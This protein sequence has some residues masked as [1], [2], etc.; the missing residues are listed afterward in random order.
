MLD[1]EPDTCASYH[2]DKHCV[3]CIL[4]YCQ[5]LYTAH[6]L[7]NVD[8]WCQ[9]LRDMGVVPM[10]PTHINH[11]SAIWVR[12][13]EANYTWV[14]SLLVSLC[15]SYTKRYG[16]V[17]AKQYDAEWLLDHCPPCYHR[18]KKRKREDRVWTTVN[19]PEGCTPFPLVVP[20]CNL[21]NDDAVE[22]YRQYYIQVKKDIVYWRHSKAPLWY[23]H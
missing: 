5:L 10:K 13:S 9:P 18:T 23:T 16:K 21:M 14:A 1:L 20:G 11:P 8:E 7:L 19:I 12:T 6:H 17:H 22:C 15:K 4:E 3:K 2:C